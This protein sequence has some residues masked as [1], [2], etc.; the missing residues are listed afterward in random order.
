MDK[1]AI[2]PSHPSA[3]DNRGVIH[4]ELTVTP[5]RILPTK[6]YFTTGYIADDELHTLIHSPYIHVFYSG[7][8]IRL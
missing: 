1:V 8:D 7:K 4:R 5:G 3:G 6:H 2:G